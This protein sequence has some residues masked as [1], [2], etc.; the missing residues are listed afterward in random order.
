MGHES[1]IELWSPN[2]TTFCFVG[3]GTDRLRRQEAMKTAGKENP[4]RCAITWQP[5]ELLERKLE[6]SLLNQS[7]WKARKHP[8][9]AKYFF[10]TFPFIELSRT[11]TSSST[12]QYLLNAET[13]IATDRD[14]SRNEL[15]L[16]QSY[17][18]GRKCKRGGR[19]KL[20][21]SA[22][23][24]RGGT[25]GPVGHSWHQFPSPC[26]NFRARRAGNCRPIERGQP[27]RCNSDTRIVTTVRCPMQLVAG[28]D[29]R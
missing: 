18:V 8:A 19:A 4:N 6:P 24:S 7:G 16:S 15:S 21:A 13:R 25:L 17:P 12:I 1:Q 3:F 23:E 9:V 14:I 10:L 2:M 20:R 22:I 29:D 28:V 5:T 26:N 11:W 27:P